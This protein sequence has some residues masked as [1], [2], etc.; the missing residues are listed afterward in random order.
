ME[1]IKEVKRL[2]EAELLTL[3]DVVSV[4]IGKGEEGSAA[5]IVGLAKPN[6]ETRARIPDRID[7][8][9]VIVR[10]SGTIRAQ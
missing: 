4:G 6:P 10:L 2:H 9:P 1:S 3:P 8:Y 5:I 7:G